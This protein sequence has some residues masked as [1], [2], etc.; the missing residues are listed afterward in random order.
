MKIV[1]IVGSIRE[2]SLN[3]GLVKTLQERYSEKLDIIMANIAQLP[4]YNQDHENSPNELVYHFKQEILSADA[5]LISTP[6]YNWSVPGVL[7]NA[8]DWLSRVDFVLRNKPVMIVG[9]STGMVG[10]LRAQLHLRQILSSPG[11]SS[12]VL[13]P[14]GNEV[15]VNQ[16][17]T[18]FEN[19]RLVD[20]PTL[21]FIDEVMGRFIEWS[22]EKETDN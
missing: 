18:K 6:E 13:P 15:I 5:V 9:V 4:F 11:L 12:R 10:T 21:L 16:A 14:S 17:L 22:K 7:K 1:A 8:L 2:D 3:F 20:E 19:G